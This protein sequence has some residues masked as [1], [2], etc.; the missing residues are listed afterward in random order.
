VFKEYHYEQQ[1]T[2]HDSREFVVFVEVDELLVCVQWR[3][4]IGRIAFSTEYNV[5]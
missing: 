1:P 5:G 4:S 3:C 2:L